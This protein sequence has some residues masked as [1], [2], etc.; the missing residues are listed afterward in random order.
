MNQLISMLKEKKDDIKRQRVER[1]MEAKF[2]KL[3]SKDLP[4]R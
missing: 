4:S 3:T 1:G 2:S